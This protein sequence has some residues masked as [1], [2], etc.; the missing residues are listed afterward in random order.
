MRGKN[1]KVHVGIGAGK[2]FAA[3]HT[4]EF[5]PRH[6]LAQP[7]LVAAV[8]ND[9]KFLFVLVERML[10]LRQ[11]PDVLF[12]GKAPDEAE[13]ADRIFKIARSFRG[14][15]EFGIDAARHQKTGPARLALK[16][17]A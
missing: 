2:L 12:D 8:T 10:D 5:R 17:R 6:A 16:Q 9:K 7:G 13:D 11:Q 15:K 14:M 4:G 3:Q 1:E